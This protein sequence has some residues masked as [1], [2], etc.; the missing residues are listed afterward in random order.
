MPGVVEV[1]KA[2]RI[3]L[4]PGDATAVNLPEFQGAVI[5]PVFPLAGQPDHDS[6]HPGIGPDPQET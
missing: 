2:G 5:A 4:G 3:D 1:G 6:F